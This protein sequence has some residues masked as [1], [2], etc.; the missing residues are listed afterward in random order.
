MNK[1]KNLL[2][3]GLTIVSIASI[4]NR[5]IAVNNN[6]SIVFGTLI[7]AIIIGVSYSLIKSKLAKE[8]K[9]PILI[10]IP[11]VF[12]LLTFMAT[13]VMQINYQ[14]CMTTIVSGCISLYGTLILVGV[15]IKRTINKGWESGVLIGTFLF[16]LGI[17]LI[18]FAQYV[19]YLE[20]IIKIISLLGIGMFLLSMSLAVYK[21]YKNSK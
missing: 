7:I 18:P 2:V 12:S 14:I 17:G 6:V 11:I 4:I 9:V 16:L 1:F 15:L 8:D 20:P 19:V 3:S 5:A 13:A 21:T 10:S